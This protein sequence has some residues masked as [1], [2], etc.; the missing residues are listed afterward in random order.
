MSLKIGLIRGDGIGP[1]IVE[2]AYTILKVLFEKHSVQAEFVELSMGGCS[3]DVYGT[4]LTDETLAQAKKCSAILLGAVGGQ[5]W[6]NA[7]LRPE[8]ALLKIR[9]ELNLYCNLRPVYLYEELISACPLKSEIAQKGIDMVVVRELNGGIYYGDRKREGDSAYDTESYSEGEVERIAIKAFELAKSRRK[10]V[11]SV[12]KANVL[13]TSKLWREVVDCV[14]KQ[15]PQVELSHML[16]DNAA[17][18]LIKDPSQFDVLLT[19]NMFGDILSDEAAVLSGSI[20]MLPSASLNEGTLGLYEPAH[21]S[22]PD[23]AGKNLA[24]P[25]ATVLSCAMMLKHS[26]HL[27]QLAEELEGSVKQFLKMGKRTKDLT[28]DES[29]LKTTEVTA[30][31]LKILNS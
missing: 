11:V 10:K 14:A 27:P 18:Q 4:P 24:N 1:E 5:K 23:I 6:D 31:L 3:I 22:A 2:S 7:P 25:L 21:G 8:W 19:S 13:T 17:M 16:V 20:G 15:Y 26:L 28:Q 30:E 9:S 29:F 12:D